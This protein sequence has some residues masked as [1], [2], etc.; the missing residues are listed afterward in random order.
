MG[1]WYARQRRCSDG[2]TAPRNHLER[3]T[4]RRQ[5]ERFLAAPPENERVASLQPDNS[6]PASRRSNQEPD[7]E[8]L[9]DRRTS[10]AFPDEN[11]LCGRREIECFGVYE[12]VIQDQI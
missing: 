6:A 1:H 9:A 5:R 4:S 8:L 3:K 7:D 12:S 11:S 10:R 2:G